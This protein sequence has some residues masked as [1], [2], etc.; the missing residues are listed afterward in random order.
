MESRL[1]TLL[2]GGE[3]TLESALEGILPR[4]KEFLTATE[5]YAAYYGGWGSG[6]SVS[7]CATVMLLARKNPGS[8][9][10][11]GRLTLPSLRDTT[12]RTFLEM[13]PLDWVEDWR[14]AENRLIMK[15]EGGL[16]EIM[17]KHLDLTD[18]EHAAHVRSLNLSGFAVDEAAEI[19][20]G[21]F[22]TLAGRLRRKG[23]PHFGRLGSNPAGKDWGW[24]MFFSAERTDYQRQNYRGIVAPTTEN[25]HLPLDY[26][27][28]MYASLPPDWYER[29]AKGEFVEFEGQ[30]YKDWEPK[31]HIYDSSVPHEF[32]DGLTDPPASWPTYVGNDI[33][34]V[35]P[36][37]LVFLRVAPNGDMFVFDEIKET[38]IL[39]ETL[40]NMYFEKLGPSNFAG[41]A[42]D[43]ENQQAAFEME[44]FGMY[45]TPAVKDIRPGIF[46]VAH[47]LHPQPSALNPFTKVYGAPQLFIASRCTG[48]IDE[49]N[50]YKW[51]RN[52]QGRMTGL[53]DDTDIH[54]L[55]G[56]R[57]ALHTFHPIGRP[58]VG[59]PLWENP[60]LDERSR[61]YWYKAEKEQERQA[62]SR[63]RPFGSKLDR[64]K[65]GGK[66]A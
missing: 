59:R 36:W 49:L 45:G 46:T 1:K 28:D 48:L 10:L 55:D 60:Q 11:V 23:T 39:I 38:G 27:Q 26:T 63:K 50:R 20:K 8:L 62:R 22:L 3:V 34:G 15:A 51:A 24:E 61:L 4:Q 2:E 47:Y 32:F 35:D 33:G 29:F 12:R 57:Y 16:S 66:A 52:R 65:V 58:E 64:L 44:R 53:P 40:S 42:Y 30:V 5:R 13:F 19:T 18:P 56:L 43:H 21:T 54:L 41:M 7:L 31:V 6:K 9:W 17:F 25:T 14:Q 37:G